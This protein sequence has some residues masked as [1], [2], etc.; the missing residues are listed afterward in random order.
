M[1]SLGWRS[2]GTSTLLSLANVVTKL[3]PEAL[4]ILCDKTNRLGLG[5]SLECGTGPC[6]NTSTDKQVQIH[7]Q[8]E[9][10]EE[11]V[12]LLFFWTGELDLIHF[13]QNWPF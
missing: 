13:H 9:G 10:Q 2:A 5:L 4:V 1:E 12:F 3:S 11:C 8:T 6:W 7:Q